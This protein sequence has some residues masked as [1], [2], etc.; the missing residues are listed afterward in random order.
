MARNNPATQSDF[1]VART[2]QALLA[3]LLPWVKTTQPLL[4]FVASPFFEC[5]VAYLGWLRQTLC[6]RT[7]D[8]LTAVDWEG[9]LKL[10]LRAWKRL[11]FSFY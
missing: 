7:G 2:T 1:C 5:L 8:T 6:I 10:A 9:V 3:I 11:M 4:G